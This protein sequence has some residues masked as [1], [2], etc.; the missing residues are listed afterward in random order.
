MYLFLINYFELTMLYGNSVD[1]LASSEAY[2][3]F[4]IEFI[5]GYTVHGISK[6]RAKLSSLSITRYHVLWDK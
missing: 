5:S 3:V 6:V 1:Q 2:T 4:S